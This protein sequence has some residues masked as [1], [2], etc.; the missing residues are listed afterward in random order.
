MPKYYAVRIGKIPGIYT[1]WDKCKAQIFKF[2]GAIYKKFT[3]ESDAF[4]YMKKDHNSIIHN[5]PNALVDKSNII[6]VYTDGDLITHE[7]II[8]AC[9]GI[10][11][12]K[13]N[14]KLI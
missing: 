11:F 14:M 10:Y 5:N 13:E 8:Y 6:N 2:P 12:D 9:Y 4:V 1:T 7:D 3:S